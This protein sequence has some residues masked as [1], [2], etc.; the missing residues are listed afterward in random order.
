MLKKVI[1]GIIV[2]QLGELTVSASTYRS[3]NVNGANNIHK[4]IKAKKP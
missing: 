2:F 3:G 4:K 1:G